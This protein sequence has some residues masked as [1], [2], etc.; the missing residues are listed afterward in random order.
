MVVIRLDHQWVIEYA[1]TFCYTWSRINRGLGKDINTPNFLKSRILV[2]SLTCV[3]S[4]R[5]IKFLLELPKFII[6]Q[7]LVVKFHTLST[8]SVLCCLYLIVNFQ[9]S[10]Q[11]PLWGEI[12][13]KESDYT[14]TT[15]INF[16]G[17]GCRYKVHLQ[18]CS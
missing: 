17:N 7:T 12:S 3:L 15:S 6:H 4:K 18:V 13:Q 11:V 5:I 2:F 16:S 14:P 9:V 10:T 1:M 8:K